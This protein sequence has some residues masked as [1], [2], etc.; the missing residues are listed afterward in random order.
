MGGKKNY[1]R[2]NTKARRQRI[3]MSGTANKLQLDRI[4][5][6]DKGI[7]QICNEPCKREDATRDHIKRLSECTVQ[8]ARSD[9]NVQLA[10]DRCNMDRHREPRALKYSIGS[11][12]PQLEGLIDGTTHALDGE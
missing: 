2:M 1:G 7:C 8:E 6:R 12:F 3:E 9:N 4:Y 10:H 5:D 11:L